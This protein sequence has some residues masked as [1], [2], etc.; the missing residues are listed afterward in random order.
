[1]HFFVIKLQICFA[2]NDSRILEA[3]QRTIIGRNSVSKLADL[4][5]GKDVLMLV[6]KAMEKQQIEVRN[7]IYVQASIK[8][9][10][11]NL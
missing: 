9:M 3:A 6:F 4:V 8:L 1:M 11:D 2:A 7:Q 5:L 10:A